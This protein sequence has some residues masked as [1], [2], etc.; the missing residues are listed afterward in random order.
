MQRVE[1]AEAANKRSLGLLKTMAQA[2][3]LSYKSYLDASYILAN[4]LMF[5]LRMVKDPSLELLN[6]ASEYHTILEGTRHL[7]IGRAC[8]RAFE[9]TMD[10]VR[11]MLTSVKQFLVLSFQNW[12]LTDVL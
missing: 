4:M 6:E 11:S 8:I 7:K 1:M 3:V 2:D 9:A 5:I 12:L 10:D